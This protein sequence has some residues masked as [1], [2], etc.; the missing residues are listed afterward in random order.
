MFRY[1]LRPFHSSPLILVVVFTLGLT[2]SVGSLFGLPLTF[3]L[4]SWFAKYCF[5][6]LDSVV[7]GDE[8]APV[9]SVEMVNPVSEQRPLAQVALVSLGVMLIAGIER[10]MGQAF[11]LLMTIALL[12]ALPASIAVMGVTGNPL[13]AAWPPSLIELIKG[14]QLDYLWLVIATVCFAGLVYISAGHGMPTWVLIALTMLCFLIT[15]SLIGGAVFEHRAELGIA[16]RT[17]KERLSERDRQDHDRARRVVLD[18]AYAQLRLRRSLDSWQAIDK[19]LAPH[20]GQASERAEYLE[21]LFAVSQW[22]DPVIGDK[23]ANEYIAILLTKRETGAAIEV[24]ERRFAS[25]PR[26]RVS[27]STQAQRLAELAGLAGK[28]SLKRR[29]E[30]TK[31]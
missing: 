2:F 3:I 23:L 31:A 17:R 1:G 7:A 26:F 25:N 18:D 30:E 4:V 27:P 11:A 21:V 19:W 12:F 22:D 10:Y 16:T 24:A 8:E 15:F 29:L 6:L 20:R 28:R 14:L 9:L 5:V 13:R